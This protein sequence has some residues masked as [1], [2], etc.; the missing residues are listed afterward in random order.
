MEIIENIALI[1]I[2][3]TMLVQ[4]L[5]FLLFMVFFNRIMIR[6]LRQVMSERAHYVEDIRQQ[7]VASDEN[8][9]EVADQIKRQENDVRQTALAI[10][11]DVETDGQKSA[12]A[13]LG[14]TK[15]EIDS[16]REKAQLR[17]DAKIAEARRSMQAEADELSEQ[18]AAVLLNRRGMS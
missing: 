14:Q 6:P 9:Q 8:L 18:M 1:S 15:Q 7:I 12:M 5:S 10:R 4:L 2:N 16:I 17:V 13:V 11:K 3:A